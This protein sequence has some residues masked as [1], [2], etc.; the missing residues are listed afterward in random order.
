MLMSQNNVKFC[1]KH[2]RLHTCNNVTYYWQYFSPKLQTVDKRWTLGS[3]CRPLW[4]KCLKHAIVLKDNRELFCF[5]SS[6]LAL[7]YS[8][9]LCVRA[10][11]TSDT[12]DLMYL[13]RSVWE[14]LLTNRLFP[15]YLSHAVSVSSL[16]DIDWVQTEKHVFEQAS[17][18]PFLV[19]LHSCFQTESR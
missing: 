13:H 16:Q 9:I 1:S 3:E 8:P 15:H 11:Q 10:V 4:F 18:N 19:G 7:H 2:C 17:T 12:S 6:W 14:S 5:P